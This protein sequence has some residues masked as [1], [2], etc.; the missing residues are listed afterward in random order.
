MLLF[1]F[2][3]RT[4]TPL[5][6]LVQTWEEDLQQM[7]ASVTKPPQYEG[8]GFPDFFEVCLSATA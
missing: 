6:R 8:T 7:W 1:V 3:D 5:A 2:R 4:K